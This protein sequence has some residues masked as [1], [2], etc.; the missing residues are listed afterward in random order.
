M[1]GGVQLEAHTPSK[2]MLSLQTHGSLGWSRSSGLDG[3]QYVASDMYVRLSPVG[4]TIFFEITVSSSALARARAFSAIRPTTAAVC[5][6]PQ[7][8][9]NLLLYERAHMLAG[10]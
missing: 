3:Q 6:Y 1:P 9:S 5:T 2:G 10:A 8:I 4:G 7:T